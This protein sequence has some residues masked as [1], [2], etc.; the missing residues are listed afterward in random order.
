MTQTMKPSISDILN[1]RS[2]AIV[3]VSPSMG[4]YWAHSMLQWEHDL[5][6]WF[7]SRSG[8]EVLGHK[9]LTSVEDIPEKIDYAIIRVPY[10]AVPE[11]LRECHRQGAKGVTIFTSG[12]SEL[13]TEEGKQR[14]EELRGILDET[15]MRAFGPNCMGLMYPK[16]GF[17]FMPTI[18]RLSGNVGFLSQSGGVAITTYTAGV[19][20]GVG[21]SKV[22]SF[23][24][25]VDI[26]PQE[27]LDYFHTDIDTKAVGAYLEGVKNGKK[28][29]DSM[30]NLAERKP[31]VV[32][33]GGR[34][35]EGSRAAASHTG[36]L[37]G[38]KEIWKA[39]FRQANVLTVDTVE[40]LIATLSIFSLSPK[41]RTRNIGLVAISG[42]TSVILT[43]LCIEKGLNVPRTSEET[44]KRL[45]PLILDVG[46][47]LGN[48]VDLAAD[49]YQDQ[50]TSEVIR[51]VGEESMFDSLIIEADVHNM[52]QAA[53][54]M[55]AADV[56]IE[57]WKVM[58]KA[59]RKVV[60]TEN[61]PVLI[62]IPEVAYPVQR[63]DAWKIFVEHGLPVFRNINE[64]ASALSRV[65]DYYENRDRRSS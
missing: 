13:G 16:I 65:C 12:F 63:A 29:L 20:S 52:Y 11:A 15:G 36:A 42:G 54:I 9:I 64:A 5:R 28:I 56:L 2:V 58:A 47:G 37:A 57:Y 17:A 33:K 6:V 31:L 55:G 50:T 8:G 7:V 48:P 59:G 38:S 45:D 44:I 25:Q 41:P 51:I 27:L 62:V 22:F 35:T 1:I 23:G 46:T 4:Y 21:F 53:S 10:K 34:S 49:Y 14:E 30:I 43:D 3:G 32:L 60:E 18:K 39:V 24:N 26:T 61:K 19:E 40:D